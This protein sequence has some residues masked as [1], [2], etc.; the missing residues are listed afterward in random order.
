MGLSISD[1]SQ[2]R[3][4][5]ER[6]L[7]Y[8]RVLFWKNG[9]NGTS[10]RDIAKAYGCRPSNIYNFFPNKEALL[11]E[12][13]LDEMEYIV[14]PIRHLENDITM[15]PVE[16]LRLLIENHIKLTLGYRRTSKLLFDT[17][18]GNL[19]RD[20]RN[21]IIALRDVYDRIL[22]RVIQRGIDSGDF[23][24]VDVK[25]AAFSIAS[26]VVRSRIWFSPKGRLSVNEFIDFVFKFTMNGLC[27]G[28]QGEYD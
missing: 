28:K 11:Y 20:K 7:A 1:K 15:S 26:M 23:A 16:Q 8:A 6:M 12:V 2:S 5:K 25:L 4:Q 9:Y 27:G 13:L 17:A 24:E 21:K 18:L 10:M 19:S 14:N 22:R 3:N